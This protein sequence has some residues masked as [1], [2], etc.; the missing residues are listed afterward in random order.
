MHAF[1]ALFC[2]SGGIV[3]AMKGDVGISLLCMIFSALNGVRAYE[4]IRQLE[5]LK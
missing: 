3:S 5:E 1:A 4:K 2:L